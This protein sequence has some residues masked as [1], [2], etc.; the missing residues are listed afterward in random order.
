MKAIIFVLISL[1]AGQIALSQ[2]VPGTVITPLHSAHS[3]L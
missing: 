2:P 3:G 1:V